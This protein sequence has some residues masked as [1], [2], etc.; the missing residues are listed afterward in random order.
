MNAH[1]ALH[2]PS[3]PTRLLP[4]LLST[5]Y[6]PDP[7]SFDSSFCPSPSRSSFIL[8]P[9][10]LPLPPCSPSPQLPQTLTLRRKAALLSRIPSRQRAPFPAQRP[11]IRL[12]ACTIPHFVTLPSNLYFLLM[13]PLSPEPN[14]IP[15]RSL[16]SRRCLNTPNKR[17]SSG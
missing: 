9:L 14:N 2:P 5:S 15:G 11:L 13:S 1:P 12:G 7:S 8:H 16:P 17:K 4:F 10:H 6:F 3:R